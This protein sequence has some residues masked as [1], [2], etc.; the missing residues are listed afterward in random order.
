ME[1][2]INIVFYDENNVMYLNTYIPRSD[3]ILYQ[4]G[5]NII[6]YGYGIKEVK[7][8]INVIYNTSLIN[9][10]H[11]ITMELCDTQELGIY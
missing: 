1:E 6:Q 2:Q 9:V 11:I 3:I 5:N 7:Q 4:K 8:I 10:L